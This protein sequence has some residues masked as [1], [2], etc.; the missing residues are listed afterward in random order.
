MPRPTATAIAQ[1][2][3]KPYRDHKSRKAE[4]QWL[5]TVKTDKFV[6]TERF[7]DLAA[8]QRFARQMRKQA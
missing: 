4:P 7:D 3:T 6:V 1:T 2:V 8:A 5:V